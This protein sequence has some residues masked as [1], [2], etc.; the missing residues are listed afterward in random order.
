MMFGLF[1]KKLKMDLDEDE[2]SDEDSEENDDDDDDDNDEEWACK[3][4]RFVLLWPYGF[5]SITLLLHDIIIHNNNVIVV[6]IET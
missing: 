4:T 5:Y 3:I 2:D 6:S 1:Q